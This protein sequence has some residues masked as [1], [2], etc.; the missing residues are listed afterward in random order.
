MKQAYQDM[1]RVQFTQESREPKMES[2]EMERNQ[3]QQQFEN[4]RVD[5]YQGMARLITASQV[6]I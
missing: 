4:S 1:K 2:R 6:P 5:A 3:P